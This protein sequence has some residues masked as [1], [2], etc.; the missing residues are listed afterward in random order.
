M[1]VH[2]LVNLESSLCVPAVVSSCLCQT[3]RR[4]GLGCLCLCFM[5]VLYAGAVGDSTLSVATHAS[6]RVSVLLVCPCVS[7]CL[8]VSGTHAELHCWLNLQTGVWQLRPSA[9]VETPNPWIPGLA[10]SGWKEGVLGWWCWRQP[11]S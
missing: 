9:W 1:N 7:V 4:R 3:K 8:S 11:R 2:V 10:S 5:Q 6:G